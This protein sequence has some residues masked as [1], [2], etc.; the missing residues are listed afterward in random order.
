MLTKL[1]EKAEQVTSCINLQLCSFL[2]CVFCY[3]SGVRPLCNKELLTYL[4]NYCV[5]CADDRLVDSL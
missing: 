2:C 3:S 5:A 4:L 1:R